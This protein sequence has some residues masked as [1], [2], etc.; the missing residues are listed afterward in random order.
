[1]KSKEK[2]K[3]S[4][5]AFLR[6]S[7]VAGGAAAVAAAGTVTAKLENEA[8]AED[9]VEQAQQKK[10]YHVTPHIEAYYRLA[11]F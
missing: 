8:P 3:S 5:R 7:A 6:G 1:M 4:R 11:K 9:V 10:G 2:S